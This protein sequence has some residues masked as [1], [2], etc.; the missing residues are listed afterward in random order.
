MA[1]TGTGGGSIVDAIDEFKFQLA[2]EVQAL[3]N[4]PNAEKHEPDIK[5]IRQLAAKLDDV[6]SDLRD[7]QERSRKRAEKLLRDA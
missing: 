1:S 3:Q 4:S 5:L 2:E 7:V 6:T